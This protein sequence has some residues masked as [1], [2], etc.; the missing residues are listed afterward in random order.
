[1]SN[2]A[3]QFNGSLA[4]IESNTSSDIPGMPGPQGPQGPAG[5]DGKD[6]ISP[7]VSV[8]NI[9]GGHTV[10][11]T[12]V[13]GA[14]SF[15]VTNGQDG[16]IGPTGPK[17]EPGPPGE[18]GAQ[19]DPGLTGPAGERG[20]QGEQGLPG[21]EGPRGEQ[22]DPGVP[23]EQGPRGDN[24]EPGPQ[25]ADGFSP[26]VDVSEVDGGHKVIITDRNGPH[27][28]IVQNGK[29]TAVD[30]ATQLSVVNV[31][32][33]SIIPW[34][35]EEAS[36]PEGWHICNGEDGTLDLRDRFIVGAGNEYEVEST[37]GEKEVQLLTK[38]M[39]PHRHY[40]PND[41]GK[42]YFVARGTGISLNT[43][44]NN[45]TYLP[46]A[47]SAGGSSS[48]IL[49]TDKWPNTNSST[50]HN[51][52]PPY[53]ALFYIQK[54]GETPTDY[55]NESRVQEL[56]KDAKVDIGTVTATIDDNTGTPEV[57]VEQ[58][59]SGLEF[60][61]KNLKGETGPK[62]AKG[63]KGDPGEPGG[64][65]VQIDGLYGFNVNEDGHLMVGYTGEEPPPFR[66]QNG[67]LMVDT[68]Y[69][70]DLGEVIGPPGPQG[71]AGA[72]SS[73][74]NI[75][76]NWYFINP[77]NQRRVSGTIEEPGYF[78]DRWKLV[79]GSVEI[80]DT[81]IYLNGTIEQVLENAL[82]DQEVT[83]S[84]YSGTNVSTNG[85]TYNKSTKTVKI[86]RK[87]TIA[88]VK[89]ELGNTQTLARQ[90]NGKWVLNDPPP[91][92][93]EMLAR[94][95]RYF[96]RLHTSGAY[97]PLCTVARYGA[98]FEGIIWLPVAMRDKPTVRYTGNWSVFFYKTTEDSNNVAITKIAA[99]RFL[100]YN[101]VFLRFEVEAT[102][103]N[104]T[105]G[106]LLFNGGATD[107][108]Y[109]E[110]DADL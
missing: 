41:E 105:S 14:H 70:R 79:S 76:D 5:K 32:I 35:G 60:Q 22:G 78:I 96:I 109:W 91:N 48:N 110:F 85:C 94:C 90:E 2:Y 27:E 38:H 86:A 101:V 62:G 66:L 51:N 93:Q 55:V 30:G 4:F 29:T 71:P 73:N 53:I 84:C 59:D 44:M 100:Q 39:P 26:T 72:A 58:T 64:P 47:S 28:F 42:N 23:G 21:P 54:I 1:M 46:E 102:N 10:T 45:T 11:I 16:P 33:G 40:I 19:G 50:P 43:S 56:L 81:G 82:P 69:E 20:P 18:K 67:H 65:A 68:P 63:A 97:S 104:A 92:P 3:G 6:G 95:Q 57:T 107:D 106:S 108:P 9:L 80:R 52:L 74:P 83:V 15:T 98:N 34:V 8:S 103:I 36:I 99:N 89:L 12:D 24:G 87:D 37:G 7:T 61:F 31:P 17:G 75:L 77:I 13:N 88:A 49:Q 25:G